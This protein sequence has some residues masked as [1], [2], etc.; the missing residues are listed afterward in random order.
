MTVSLFVPFINKPDVTG[1]IPVGLTTAYEVPAGKYARVT[2]NLACSSI[3]S[4]SGNINGDA[5]NPSIS[6]N[7]LSFCIWL[8][9]GDVISVSSSAPTSSQTIPGNA[10]AVVSLAAT[11][12]A[13]YLIN[14]NSYSIYSSGSA[15]GSASSTGGG[16]STFSIS[17]SATS[18]AHYEEYIEPT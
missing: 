17:T 1:Q 5:I 6:A 15:C 13:T 2:F 4:Q 14:G 10:T 9:S 16:P 11:A 7:S 12:S 18:M 8:K 3:Y